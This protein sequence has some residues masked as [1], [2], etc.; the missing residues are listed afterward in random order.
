MSRYDPLERYILYPDLIKHL[1]DES[2]YPEI[3]ER[4]HRAI[5]GAEIEM[6]IIQDSIAVWKQG[7][8]FIKEKTDK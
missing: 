4:F 1:D 2:I 5:M 7:L 3:Q 8:D 6:E